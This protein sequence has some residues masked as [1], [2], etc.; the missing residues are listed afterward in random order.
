[1]AR[2]RYHH[3][4][5]AQ[6]LADKSFGGFQDHSLKGGQEVMSLGYDEFIAPIVKAIQEQQLIIEKL[7][8]EVEQLK[9]R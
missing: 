7:K 3:G 4:F 5:I 6:D 8:L 9:N 1:M 2:S